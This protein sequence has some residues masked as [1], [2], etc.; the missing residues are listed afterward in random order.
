MI[1]LVGVLHAEIQ[2]CYWWY[3]LC[4]LRPLNDICLYTLY[5]MS[6]HM[7]CTWEIWRWMLSCRCF[8][9]SSI[10]MLYHSLFFFDWKAVSQL[11]LYLGTRFQVLPILRWCQNHMHGSPDLDLQ[12]D[13]FFDH[14]WSQLLAANHSMAVIHFGFLYIYAERDARPIRYS[15]WMMEP[16]SFRTTV[17]FQACPTYCLQGSWSCSA[18]HRQ[19]PVI[20]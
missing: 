6:V 12:W 13:Q 2:I 17:S 18:S 3:F 20:N 16:D 11:M 15:K 5:S 4:D 9:S 19:W 8:T 10:L 14:S 1:N 7:I